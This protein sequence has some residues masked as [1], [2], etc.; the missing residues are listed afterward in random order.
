MPKDPSEGRDETKALVRSRK[1]IKAGLLRRAFDGESKYSPAQI[2]GMI[3]DATRRSKSLSEEH[4]DALMEIDTT[5]PRSVMM[6]NALARHMGTPLRYTDK[7]GRN[8]I[9]PDNLTIQ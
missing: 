6:L 4:R 7:T 5:Q 3:Q 8:F 1:E 2:I 9:A